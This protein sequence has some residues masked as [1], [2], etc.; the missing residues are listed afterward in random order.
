MVVR[1][2]THRFLR[3]SWIL[4]LRHCLRCMV[5]PLLQIAN[6][7]E[8]RARPVAPW[9]SVTPRIIPAAAAF[10]L[11]QPPLSQTVASLAS[12]WVGGGGGA[13]K[14]AVAR[15]GPVAGAEAMEVDEVDVAAGEAGARPVK[16]ARTV[17]AGWSMVVTTHAK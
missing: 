4:T 12:F 11:P 16:R 6:A 14:V 2:L 1:T 15:G 9:F 7:L 17:P 5:H 3:P 10:H 8:E 13:A